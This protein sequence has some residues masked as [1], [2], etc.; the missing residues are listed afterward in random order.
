MAW[1]KHERSCQR[2]FYS[3]GLL[4]YLI[5]ASDALTMARNRK[6]PTNFD[7]TAT[8]YT[9]IGTPFA[10]INSSTPLQ[11]TFRFRIL[12]LLEFQVMNKQEQI[13]RK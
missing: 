10:T 9:S 7:K 4:L 8:P 6:L 11:F 1:Q 2:I 12:R 5:R 3:S 13:D